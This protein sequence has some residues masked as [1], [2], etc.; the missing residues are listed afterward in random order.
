MAT[1]PG[2]DTSDLLQRMKEIESQMAATR[3]LLRDIELKGFED[4]VATSLTG[5][6]LTRI[7]RGFEA[8]VQPGTVSDEAL[9]EQLVRLRKADAPAGQIDQIPESQFANLRDFRNTAKQITAIVAQARGLQEAP[10]AG[11][12]SARA[13][14]TPPKMT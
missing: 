10:A 6:P 5:L 11:A 9:G 13:K 2:S 8:R 1:G 4:A 14:V 3:T 7:L 12:V